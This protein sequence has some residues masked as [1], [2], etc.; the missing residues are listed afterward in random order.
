MYEKKLFSRLSRGCLFQLLLA[1]IVGPIAIIFI[2]AALLILGRTTSQGDDP[3]AIAAFGVLLLF[4]FLILVV[5]GVIGYFLIKKRARNFDAAFA[6]WGLTGRQAGLVMR[7]WHGLVDGRTL[8]VW[9]SKGPTL[10]IF[11][12]VDCRTRGVIH[13]EKGKLFDIARGLSNKKPLEAMPAGYEGF[14]ADSSDEDWI[15]RLLESPAAAESLHALVGKTEGSLR[16]FTALIITPNA[17]KY[18]L[19]FLPQSAINK[20]RTRQWIDHLLSLASAIDAIGPSATGEESTKVD[21][22]SRVERGK[23]LGKIMVGCG[24]GTVL[25][26]MVFA[27]VLFFALELNR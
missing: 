21:D 7:G 6:P 4:P 24:C 18:R 22:W 14:T 26:F 11:L 1:A 2:A 12:G 20:E 19:R 8:D 9:F 3:R 5:G 27:V 13:S 16:S 15:R 23:H 17:L 25:F 10:E